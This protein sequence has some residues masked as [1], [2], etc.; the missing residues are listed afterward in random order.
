MVRPR[1]DP[2]GR[3]PLPAPRAADEFVD[4]LA[5]HLEAAVADAGLAWPAGSPAR[6]GLRTRAVQSL[7]A[8][9]AV[10]RRR[11]AIEPAVRFADRALALATGDAERL[12]ALELRARAFH[13]AVRGDEALAAYEEGMEL[14]RRLGDDEARRRLRSHALPLWARYIGAFSSNEFKPRAAALLEQGLAEGGADTPRFEAGALLIGRS[15]GKARW[16]A[17]DAAAP[18]PR[19]ATPGARSRSPRRVLGG[20]GRGH[21]A[22]DRRRGD[23]PA[24]RRARAAAAGVHRGAVQRL[25]AEI[26]VR[27]LIGDRER[28]DP[29]LEQARALARPACAPALGCLADWGHGVRLA[30]DGREREALALGDAACAALAERGERYTAERLLAE[31]LALAGA[32]EALVERTAARLEAMGA[33]ASACALLTPLAAPH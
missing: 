26:P 14:A 17:L 33:F 11:S 21:A 23:R 7:L 8:A 20:W 25:R 29:L 16:H 4:L 19:S 3:L 27:A 31:L 10:A 1:P 12:A 30:Q 9:G 6:E 15:W 28:L 24:A 13:G 18:G 22:G 5:H 2:R 32:P